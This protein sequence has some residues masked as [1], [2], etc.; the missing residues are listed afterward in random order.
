MRLRAQ[1]LREYDGDKKLRVYMKILN[2]V[3]GVEYDTIA[4][5]ASDYG[6]I[7]TDKI[8]AFLDDPDNLSYEERYHLATTVMAY[9]AELQDAS[10]KYRLYSD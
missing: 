3:Y 8:N 5:L 2:G 9:A 10:K 6:D 1:Y 4:L 7:A